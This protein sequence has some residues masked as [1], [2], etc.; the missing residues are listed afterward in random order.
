[1]KNWIIGT[2]APSEQT[3]FIW[4]MIGSTIY[5]FSSMI[6][7]YLTIRVIG[8]EDGGIFAIGLTLAQM[9][10]YIAYYEMRNFQVTDAGNSYTFMDYHAVKVVNCVIMMLVS[11]GYIWIKH[12]DSYKAYVIFLVCLYRMLDG[13]A[14]VYESQFHK[15]GRLDLAGKSMAFRTLLSVI[16]YFTILVISHNLILSLIGAV[17]S[18]IIGVMVFNIWIYRDF[19]QIHLRTSKNKMVGIWRDCFPLFVG[20]FMWT[21][22]LS[23]SRIAVDDV[24]TSEYQSYYQVLFMPV[25]VIN[26]FAGFLIRP[27]LIP[28]TEYRARGEYASFWRLIG[29]I[30]FEIS[31]ITVVCMGGAYLVGIPVLSILVG[32]DLNAYRGLLTFL[33]FSGGF[34]AIAYILYHVLTITRNRRSI[35]LGYIA[36]SVTAFMISRPLTVAM[37]LFGA[38]LSY[39]ISVVVLTIAFVVCIVYET[40]K[41]PDY[42]E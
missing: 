32:V 11:I 8:A 21:Y 41:Q 40:K 23:A 30:I 37:A 25:S 24:M 2:K 15:D 7:T 36:A 35:L 42:S 29:R 4:N 13:Y 39:L 38:A 16:L 5:A 31:I 18:G 14:D 27:S 1:M 26:L 20:M 33:V 22:L 9:Y 3:L 17:I 34:N 19:G 28:L 6:L 10:V 12:Y